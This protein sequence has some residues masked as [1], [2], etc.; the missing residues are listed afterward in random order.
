[1]AG[2]QL[3]ARVSLR[4]QPWFQWTGKC[5]ETATSHMQT[6]SRYL[7]KN[8]YLILIFIVSCDGLSKPAKTEAEN[9]KSLSIN[10]ENILDE[11]IEEDVLTSFSNEYDISTPYLHDF[12]IDSESTGILVSLEADPIFFAWSKWNSDSLYEIQVLS[13]EIELKTDVWVGMSVKEF[14]D[15]YPGSTANL[16]V[17]NETSEYFI[18]NDH[19]EYIVEFFTKPDSRIGKYSNDQYESEVLINTKRK[20][21]KVLVRRKTNG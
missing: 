10:I 19:Y 7:M 3:P 4:S 11:M 15:L 6:V 12:G 9:Y 16:E 14:I 8:I 2:E 18:V 13:E 20:A 5:F 21:N 17:V 1:M